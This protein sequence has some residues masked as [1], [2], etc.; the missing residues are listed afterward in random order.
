M[1]TGCTWQQVLEMIPWRKFNVQ[2]QAERYDPKEAFQ[3]LWLQFNLF[4][5]NPT[6]TRRSIKPKTLVGL[7]LWKLIPATLW[8]KCSR[9]PTM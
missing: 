1:E 6:A 3:K 8:M 4:H 5:E 2:F 9:K 7:Q